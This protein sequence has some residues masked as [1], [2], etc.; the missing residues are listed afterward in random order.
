MLWTQ[1]KEADVL[2]LHGEGFSAAEIARKLDMQ[3]FEIDIK[4][5]EL[6]VPLSE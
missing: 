4:L 2:R 5:G 6:G 3:T 1:D